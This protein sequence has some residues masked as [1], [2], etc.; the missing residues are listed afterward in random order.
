S[1]STSPVTR[2]PSIRSFMRLSVRR[3]VDLPQPEGPISAITDRSGIDSPM[4]NRACFSPY[5]NDRLRTENLSFTPSPLCGLRPLRL[6]SERMAEYDSVDIKV[7]RGAPRGNGRAS[8]GRP[9]RHSIVPLYGFGE[10]R[11][12]IQ[13]AAPVRASGRQTVKVVPWPTR[14]EA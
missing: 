12:E 9:W 5:Q 2:A 14:L 10:E 7:S 4:S 6:R 13:R 11:G 8:D 1:S 3:N